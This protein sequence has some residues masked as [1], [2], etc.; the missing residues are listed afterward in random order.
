MFQ[1]ANLRKLAQSPGFVHTLSSIIANESIFYSEHDV[2][3]RNRFDL[4]SFNEIAL[5]VG[6][7]SETSVDLSFPRTHEMEE[8]YKACKVGL[9][10]LHNEI[11][12]FSKS[13]EATKL[14]TEGRH[15]V[16]PIF[17]TAGSAFWFDH[18]T[19]APRLYHLDK[20]FLDNQQFEISEFAAL[21]DEMHTVFKVRLRDF[22]R[23]QR[24][25]IRKHGLVSSPLRCFIYSSSDLK[26]TG[27]ATFRKFMDRFSVLPGKTPIVT[28]PLAYHPGKVR[29]ALRLS[30]AHLYAPSI[31]MLCEQLFESP[32]YAITQDKKYFAANANNR[33]AASELKF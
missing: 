20:Q 1:T 23:E 14:F 27:E 6:L 17:Y 33:G 11:S 26:L 24:K 12:E 29:P 19:L 10:N 21:L 13:G 30:E 28:D 22:I 7:M 16:E 15:F 32:F 25:N 9:E 4:I 8:Q 5:I 18:L 2:K 31:P 3:T